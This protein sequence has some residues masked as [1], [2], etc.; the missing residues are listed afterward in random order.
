MASSGYFDVVTEEVHGLASRIRAG[1]ETMARPITAQLDGRMDG[2]HSRWLGPGHAASG[3]VHGEYRT[4]STTRVDAAVATDRRPT[5]TPVAKTYDSVDLDGRC[6]TDGSRRSRVPRRPP[7]P[8]TDN[9]RG[10][11]MT[12]IM[13]QLTTP[14]TKARQACS[15]QVRSTRRRPTADDSDAKRLDRLLERRSS[16]C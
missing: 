8:R 4:L 16:R 1:S 12:H 2:M 9:R 10:E 3:Q 11:A 7:E 13:A 14:W 6:A 5:W 15:G